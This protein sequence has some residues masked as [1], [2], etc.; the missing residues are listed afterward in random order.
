MIRI[1]R[2]SLRYYILPIYDRGQ[3]LI[4]ATFVL[5]VAILFGKDEYFVAYLLLGG[6]LGAI[7][8]SISA[9]LYPVSALAPRDDIANIRRILDSAPR[10]VLIGPDL[11]APKRYKSTLWRSSRVGF[12][13]NTNPVIVKG[14]IRDLRLID[15]KLRQSL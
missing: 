14:R 12:I 4:F 7:A 2:V 11:W 15:A 10:M 9:G 3:A 5:F 13:E 1:N 6:Y 8:M